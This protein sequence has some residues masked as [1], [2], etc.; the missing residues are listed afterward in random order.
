MKELMDWIR[1]TYQVPCAALTVHKDG[2]ELWYGNFGYADEEKKSALSRDSLFWMYSMSKVFTVSLVMKL[3]GEGKIDLN[4]PVS[5][6]LPEYASLHLRESGEKCR[7][8]L[9]VYHLMS[10]TGGLDYKSDTPY[11]QEFTEKTHHK[12]TTREVAGALAANGLIFEPGTHF[13]YSLCHDV[14]GGLIEEVTGTTFGKALRD[15]IL[16]PLNIGDLG[17]FP[18]TEQKKRIVN[19][20][21]AP[22]EMRS[23]GTENTLT[24]SS[25]QESGGAGLFGSVDEYCKLIDMLSCG[26]RTA[27]GET[28]LTPEAVAMLMKPCDLPEAC[29]RD[30]QKKFE[31]HDLKCYRY[32]L[33]VR[34]RVREDGTSPIGEFGWDG[35]A[36]GYALADPVNHI[37]I[38]YMQSILNHGPAFSD[39]H[40][41]I[42]REV[43]AAL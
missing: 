37:S 19:Q 27:E 12:A 22:E 39:I 5:D 7:N 16:D 9:R 6:Y 2:K 43:Y 42:R 35:A 36:G 3:V 28:L 17:F 1:D 32:G 23:A 10:M 20:Y 31:D 11:L 41:A 21:M 34:V 40:P 8:I 29:D 4:A 38:T 30:F 13:E 15:Q 18:D 33:G 26:G 14:L 25:C 24:L